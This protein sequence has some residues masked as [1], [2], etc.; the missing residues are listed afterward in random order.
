MFLFAGATGT[1]KTELAK[2]LAEFL[3]DDENR[4]IQIDMSEYMEKHNVSRLLGAPPGYV[5]HEEEGQLTG[6][7]R[8]HPYSV[9]LFDE[10]EKA[11]PDVLNIFLQVF[12]EGRLTDAHGRRVSFTE[13]VIILT[14]NLGAR[15]EGPARPIGLQLG[16][17]AAKGGRTDESAYRQQIMDAVR[18]ALRPE[19]LNRIRNIVIF[20][21]LSEPVVRRIVDKF[22]SR[23]RLW[24]QDR[25]VDVELTQLAYQFL[26]K[27]GFDPQFGARA[28]ERT[29]QTLIEEPLSMALL[30][31]RF[32]EG[33]TVRVD[34]RDGEMVFEAAEPRPTGNLGG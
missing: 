3:F 23:L 17:A 8:T 2:A 27:E 18:G 26:T 32:A 13:T 20:C 10:V 12:D 21:P 29:I 1:G 34:A 4:L 30:E 28:M 24:L 15:A 16:E 7:V 19:L 25:K 5:G 14:S 9:V 22:I 11:H 31:G 6:P 33:T